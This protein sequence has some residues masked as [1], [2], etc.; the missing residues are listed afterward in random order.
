MA[1]AESLQTS[2]S[3][4]QAAEPTASDPFW[5]AAA[6]G[7]ADLLEAQRRQVS[8]HSI[9]PGADARV[10]GGV[11][12]DPTASRIRATS[13]HRGEPRPGLR[14]RAYPGHFLGAF[15]YLL[16]SPPSVWALRAVRWLVEQKA[17]RAQA[18]CRG[19]HQDTC[20]TA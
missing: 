5:Q 17:T 3:Q 7:E 10:A 14:S 8:G 12:L 18:P 2:P 6:E 16:R 15:S 1:S 11:G 19:P 20:S 13:L 9:F 4:I